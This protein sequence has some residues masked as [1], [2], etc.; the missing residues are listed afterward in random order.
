M[1]LEQALSIH[2]HFVT[3]LNG[4]TRVIR[5]RINEFSPRHPDD[6]AK[7]RINK[8]RALDIAFLLEKPLVNHHFPDIGS[9]KDAKLNPM[10]LCTQKVFEGARGNT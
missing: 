10:N 4:Q 1:D 2:S 3:S 6:D 5:I 9:H 8:F 7:D